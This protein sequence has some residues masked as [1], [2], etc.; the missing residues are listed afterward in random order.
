MMLALLFS[1]GICSVEMASR[2][3]YLRSGSAHVSIVWESISGCRKD[4]D[5]GMDGRG[6]VY[7]ER[8]GCVHMG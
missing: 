7:S 5:G 4:G 3:P 8:V 6:K 2:S 1:S